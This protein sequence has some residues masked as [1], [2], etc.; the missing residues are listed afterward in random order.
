MYIYSIFFYKYIMLTD[1]NTPD[2]QDFMDET[3]M[4]MQPNSRPVVDSLGLITGSSGSVDIITGT[5]ERTLHIW[6]KVNET[7]SWDPGVPLGT[8]WFELFMQ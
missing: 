1:M 4:S 5:M 3:G 6:N 8:K 7:L 2:I